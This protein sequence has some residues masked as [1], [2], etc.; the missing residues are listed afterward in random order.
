MRSD[1]RHRDNWVIDIGPGRRA[2]IIADHD[3]IVDEDR[4]ESEFLGLFRRGDD[5]RGEDSKPR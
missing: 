3:V 5:G 4:I 1:E 2:S